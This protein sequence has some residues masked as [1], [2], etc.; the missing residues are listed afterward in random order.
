MQIGRYVIY[1]LEFVI[2]RGILFSCDSFLGKRL[3]PLGLYFC[4]LALH[5]HQ[6][7]RMPKMLR[8]LRD[9]VRQC[10]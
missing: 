1:Y 6:I 2:L 4:F 8:G 9:D 10:S 7:H 5:I 3:L